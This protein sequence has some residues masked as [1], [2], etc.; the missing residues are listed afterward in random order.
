MSERTL[1]YRRCGGQLLT[2]SQF[3]YSVGMTL[4]SSSSSLVSVDELVGLFRTR[5]KDR[6]VDLNVVISGSKNSTM[7][8]IQ[9]RV[10]ISVLNT[11]TNCI[12]QFVKCFGSNCYCAIVVY[13]VLIHFRKSVLANINQPIHDYLFFEVCN[14]LSV[15]GAHVL[16]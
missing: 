3:K 1:I 15:G 16:A 14:R 13:T 5:G 11:V 8:E 6:R 9:S 10:C 4:K 2:S 12:Y 7:A